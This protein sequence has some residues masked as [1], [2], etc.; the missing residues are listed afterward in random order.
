MSKVWNE[1]YRTDVGYTYGYYRETSPVYQRFCLLLRGL[2]CNDSDEA[3]AH[4]ELGFGQG[5]SVNINAA[6]NPGQ[7][8]ATDFNPAHAAHARG[9]ASHPGGNL[10]LHDDSFEQLLARDDLPQFDSISLHGIVRARA[11]A[12]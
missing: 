4:C 5:V 2:A 11:P 12:C 3:A 7:Y 8:V 10:R 1:G 9:M 6:S